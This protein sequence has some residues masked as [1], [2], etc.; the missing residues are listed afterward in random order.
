MNYNN[1]FLWGGSIA[2]HQLE[3]AY[4]EGGKGLNTMDLFTSGSYEVP[5][6]VTESIQA[7]KYYPSHTGIDFYHRYQED[8]KLFADMGFTALRLSIDWARIF[9]NGDDKQP[10]QEGLNF[11][12][13]VIDELRRYNIKPIVTLFHFELP[14][15]IVKKYNSWLSRET[16]NLYLRFVKTVVTEYKG[17]VNDWVTFNEMNHIDPQT[18]VSD[19]FT[20]IIAGLECSKMENKKQVV[21]TIGYNMTLASVKAVKLIKEIDSKNQ[22]GCVFGLSPYYPKTCKP[23]DVLLSFQDTI[24]D[25]YQID[26]MMLGEFPKY[27]LFEYQKE[28]IQLTI[29]DEDRQAFKE[30]ILDFIGLNYYM[31]AVSSTEVGENAQESMFGGEVNPYLEKSDWGWTID[32]VG[33]RYLLNFIYRKYQKPIIICENGLG[34]VDEISETGEINDSYRIDYLKKH[35][36]QVKKAIVEDGVECFGYLM[37]GPID[38]VSATTG[39]MKKRYGFIYVDK[40]DDGTGDLSRKPKKSY[41]WYKE[42][43]AANGGNL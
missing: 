13:N 33:L 41:Y 6:Q 14:I 10:N 17:K 22:V 20:Y 7:D 35:L 18:E 30:G 19:V 24:R 16:I 4:N 39:E 29:S 40:Q 3:G 34:A 11:Y 31:S 37:W 15:A 26:A 42:T 1:E 28:G 27:K 43:I 32:P 21:A 36:A 23:E 25:F 9:P 5:R 8:I 2:A 38:L 12:H